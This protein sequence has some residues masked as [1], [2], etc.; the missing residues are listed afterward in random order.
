MKQSSIDWLVEQLKDKIG[1]GITIVF[2]EEIKQAREMH[3]AEIVDAYEA[4]FDDSTDDVNGDG[5]FHDSS[6]HYY[7]RTYGGSDENTVG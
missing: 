2:S 6:E 7:N 5:A 4:G 3:K 1:S